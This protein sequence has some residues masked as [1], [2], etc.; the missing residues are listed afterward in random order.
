MH[1]AVPPRCAAAGGGCRRHAAHALARAIVA[2]RSAQW[3]RAVPSKR[4]KRLL[5]PRRPRRCLYT[6]A[7][8]DG[9]TRQKLQECTLELVDD[10]KHSCVMLVG[11]NKG[12]E[13]AASSLSGQAIKLRTASA[14]LLQVG[15]R[16]CCCCCLLACAQGHASQRLPLLNSRGAVPAAALALPQRAP[17]CPCAGR[18]A[19]L[20]RR[21]DTRGAC[22]AP[23][24]RAGANLV[25][26]S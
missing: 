2:H 4:K 25:I 11:H 19:V 18:C 13:E 26:A 6:V 5:C 9:M 22:V 21:A 14:A 3:L 20:V 10:Q 16:R 7:A 23:G 15:R 8:L 12:W 1:R 17:W 24:G